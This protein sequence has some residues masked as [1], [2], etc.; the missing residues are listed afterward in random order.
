MA[1][2]RRFGTDEKAEA[3]L[4][5]C[6]WPDGIRCAYCE[7]GRWTPGSPRDGEGIAL[8]KYVREQ[9]ST[10][11]ARTVEKHLPYASPIGPERTRLMGI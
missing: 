3:R 4:V 6:C 5:E 11:T 9:A 1:A 7:S 10:M 2:I 8:G